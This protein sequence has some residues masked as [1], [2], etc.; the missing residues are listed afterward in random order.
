MLRFT[1]AVMV[2]VV[3]FASA[4]LASDGISG[5]TRFLSANGTPLTTDWHANQDVPTFLVIHGFRA[6]GTDVAFVEQACTIQKRFPRANVVIVDWT[7]RA[8]SPQSQHTKVQLSTF[9]VW[10]WALDLCTDY[11]RAAHASK[12]I[13]HDIARWMKHQAIEPSKT[14]ICGHSLGAQI[15]GFASKHLAHPE[16][17]GRRIRTILAADP[18]GPSF[19]GMPAEDRLDKADAEEVIVIH[20]TEFLGDNRAIGSLDIYVSW[21]ESDTPDPIA[22]HSLRGNWLLVHSSTPAWLPMAVFPS[23]PTR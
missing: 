17:L 20:T 15:A 9:D 12:G 8:D 2:V 10:N 13:G 16:M 18:A 5:V 3:L 19:S 7:L 21:R 1:S 6:R 22:R 11:E 14:S 23:Q 4:G